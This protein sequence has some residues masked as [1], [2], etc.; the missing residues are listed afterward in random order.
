VNR[1]R[2][3]ALDLDREASG[4]SMSRNGLYLVIALLLI[5]VVGFGIYTYQQQNR[6]GVEVRVDNNGISIDG[7]G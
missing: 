7:N 2:R 3:G 1:L 6:P 4:D 5:V